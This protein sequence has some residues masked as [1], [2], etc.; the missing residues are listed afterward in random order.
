MF[1]TTPWICVAIVL[2]QASEAEVPHQTGLIKYFITSVG[3]VF[4]LCFLALGVSIVTILVLLRLIADKKRCIPA[5]FVEQFTNLINQRKTTEAY[6]F[7]RT[8]Q[9]PLARILDVGICH[10]RFGLEATL[11]T[12]RTQLARF[13]HQQDCTLG[14]LRIGAT[15]SLLLGLLGSCWHAIMWAC[16]VEQGG[17]KTP[18][19]Q[20][21]PFLLVSSLTSSV[22]GIVLCLVAMVGYYIFQY[23]V[24]GIALEM[25][26]LAESYLAQLYVR[27]SDSSGSK[28]TP[29]SWPPLVSGSPVNPSPF[30]FPPLRRGSG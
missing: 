19:P 6:E 3:P 21:L 12:A 2:G 26:A 24:R 16:I 13:E 10:F 22:V 4:G 9:S 5:E 18:P 27:G 29:G 25:R 11:S 14:W 7:C 17:P 28:V 15:T 30:H 20:M 23:R 8:E 1:A